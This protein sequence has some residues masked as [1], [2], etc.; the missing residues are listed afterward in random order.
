MKPLAP[1]TS[2]LATSPPRPSLLVKLVHLLLREA[3][4]AVARVVHHHVAKARLRLPQPP[5]LPEAEADVVVALGH[6][7]GGREAFDD[8]AVAFERLGGLSGTEETRGAEERAVARRRGVAAEQDR[9][10]EVVDRGRVVLLLEG[11][12]AELVVVR[13]SVGPGDVPEGRR[14]DADQP[15]SHPDRLRAREP[16]VEHRR[17][18]ASG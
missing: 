4:P 1:V 6:P 11:L 7:D 15:H 3:C 13:R 14:E 18:F 2:T 9:A 12:P 10:V 5:E 8:G 17:R 16:A